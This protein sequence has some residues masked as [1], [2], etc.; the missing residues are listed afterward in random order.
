ME[1][2]REKGF[3]RGWILKPRTDTCN[4]RV[5]FTLIST[6]ASSSFRILDIPLAG[7]W[8]SSAWQLLG[9]LRG[10]LGCFNS[11]ILS[12][13]RKLGKNVARNEQF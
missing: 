5:N 6:G 13:I 12:W 3:S 11:A 2:P 10:A 4:F 7:S 8:S 1:V 9:S